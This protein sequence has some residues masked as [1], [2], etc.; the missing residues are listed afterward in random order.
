[1]SLVVGQELALVGSR[2]KEEGA[3]ETDQDGRSSL[4]DEQKL[5][6]S[7]SSGGRRQTGGS[8]E[9]MHELTCQPYTLSEWI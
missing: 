4:G 8:A 7:N 5:R 1:M 6:N 2:G 9:K 3:D